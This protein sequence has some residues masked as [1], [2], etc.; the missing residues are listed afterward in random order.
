LNALDGISI[1]VLLTLVGS[2]LVVAEVFFP[3]GGV[4]G[5]LST[6]AFLGAIYS[7]YTSG[8]WLY[9]LGFAAIEVTIAPLLLYG[10]F[11]AL[12]KTP[13]GRLLVGEA[14]TEAEVLPEDHHRGLVGRVGIARSKMLPAGSVE[15]DG[16]ML[17][18]VSQGQAIEPG[19]YV[20]VVEA[21]RTR[22]V[23]R[24]ASA[25]ERPT[26]G[27]STA[28]SDV[29]SRPATELGLEDIDFEAKPPA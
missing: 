19:E 18:A 2:L 4:L 24:R 6:A 20:K 5:L 17:D 7:A 27:T 11:T 10:A 15:V 29:L 14:P 1:A 13:M 3:S 12:P 25:T 22:I 21:S 8:G 26:P 23:V 28:K 9:G 16:Q